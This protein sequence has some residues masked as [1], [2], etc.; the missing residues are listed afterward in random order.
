MTRDDVSR[1]DFARRYILIVAGDIAEAE[2]EK[3]LR[4]R[5]LAEQIAAEEKTED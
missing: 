4:L 5:E 2:P 1:L 3:A